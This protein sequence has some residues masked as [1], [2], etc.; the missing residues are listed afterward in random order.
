MFTPIQKI[1]LTKLLTLSHNKLLN[2]VINTLKKFDLD[3]MRLKDSLDMLMQ[4]K[5]QLKK[6]EVSHGKHPLTKEMKVK[7]RED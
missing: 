4:L 3:A 5:P 7:R 1:P 6:L 2:D